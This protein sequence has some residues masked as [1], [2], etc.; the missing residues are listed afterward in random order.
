[1]FELG[2]CCDRGS[3]YLGLARALHY[4]ARLD[5]AVE[6]EAA[7]LIDRRHDVD[8]AFA[9]EVVKLRRRQSVELHALW[10][11]RDWLRGRLQLVCHDRA[12]GR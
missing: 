9:F 6:L 8:R 10:A 7:V 11:D 2:G 3:A 4:V 1:M 5:D 12:H